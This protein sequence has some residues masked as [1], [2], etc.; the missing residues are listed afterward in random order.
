MKKVNWICYLIFILGSMYM[1][2]SS[3]T[4]LSFSPSTNTVNVGDTFDDDV[5]IS[6]L[7][8]ANGS[9]EIVSAFDLDVL[10]DPTVLN[11]TGVAF[12][13][14]LGLITSTDPFDLFSDAWIFTG[15]SPGRVDFG[16]SSWL[17]N[18]DLLTLQPNDSFTL[19]TLS[20]VSLAEGFSTLI[21]DPVVFPGVDVKGYDPFI[22]FDLSN[23]T[24]QG[25]VTVVST[26]VPE[27]GVLFLM[28]S[29]LLSL[30]I[31]GRIKTIMK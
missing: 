8:A 2:P 24:E 25:A 28:I 31:A 6:D 9:R 19:A 10:Y 14:S 13:T 17:P 29:G 11:A 23:S 3:A 27:P 26:A 12:G 5:V 7:Y 21:F 22:P 15:L 16:E 1:G 4:L 20:F 18:A 30:G